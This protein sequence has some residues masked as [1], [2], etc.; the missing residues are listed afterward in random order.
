[1][2]RQMLQKIKRSVGIAQLETHEHGEKPPDYRPQHSCYEELFCDYLMIRA[3]YVPGDKRCLFHGGRQTEK[4]SKIV[5]PD[6]TGPAGTSREQISPSGKS[7]TSHCHSCE[8]AGAA[9]G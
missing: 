6:A 4:D 3:E 5:P 1:M 7:S 8:P 9:D 2:M